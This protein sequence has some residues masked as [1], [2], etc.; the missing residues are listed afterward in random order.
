MKILESIQIYFVLE[1]TRK[2]N[3]LALRRDN[4]DKLAFCHPY[5]KRSK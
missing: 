1:Q 2:G 3:E 5:E 4:H